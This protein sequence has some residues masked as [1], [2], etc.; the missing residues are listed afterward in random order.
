[1]HRAACAA[2]DVRT[3]HAHPRISQRQAPPR[4]QGSDGDD[5]RDREM[6]LSETD[7]SGSGIKRGA[8]KA[9]VAAGVS[10]TRL[11][12]APR[13]RV[14]PRGGVTPADVEGPDGDDRRSGLQVAG[15][16]QV[17]QVGTRLG[18]D[19]G[20]RR[21]GVWAWAEWAVPARALYPSDDC[22][23]RRSGSSGV[24]HS[25]RYPIP[26]TARRHCQLPQTWPGARSRSC[27]RS[28]TKHALT[29]SRAAG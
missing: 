19:C 15:N 3:S 9:A 21:P 12:E 7:R 28:R 23:K 6:D 27:W 25:G 14:E 24:T 1:M 29:G 4:D 2:H 5:R 8:A 11:S 20:S 13:A 26:W 10:Q 22:E 16:R 17:G 18:R